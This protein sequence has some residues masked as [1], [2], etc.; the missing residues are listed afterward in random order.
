VQPLAWEKL[1]INVGINA[2]TAL[3]RVTNGQLINSPNCRLILE[4]SAFSKVLCTVTLYNKCA[5][6]LTFENAPSL[7]IMADAVKEAH[8]VVISIVTLFVWSK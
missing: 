8:A 5:R 3:L 2:L 4:G 6:T 1:C 7:P